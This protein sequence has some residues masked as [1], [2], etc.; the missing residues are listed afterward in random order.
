M[1]SPIRRQRLLTFCAVVIVFMLYRVVQNSWDESATYAGLRTYDKP[2]AA[3]QPPPPT[4]YKAPDVD[5]AAPAVERPPKKPSEDDDEDQRPIGTK[6][7]T[8][9]HD[10][11]YDDAAKA[12]PSS[13][14]SD[15]GQDGTGK[16][17]KVSGEAG[18]D[19]SKSSGKGDLPSYQSSKDGWD[20]QWKKPPSDESNKAL[21]GNEKVHW[22]KTPENFPLPEESIA[23]LPT[24][25][26]KSIPK[27]QYEFGKESESAKQTRQQRLKRVKTEIE[28]SWS[29][30]RKNAWMHDELSPVSG[31]NRDPFCSW[32]ATLV[33]SLDTLWI[34][35]LKDEF[36]EAVQAVRKIDF[37]WTPRNE[38]PVFETTIRYLGGLL[39][40][41][42]VSGG[43]DG[44]YKVLLDKAVE[45][46]EILMGIF[47]TPNRMPLLFYQWQPQ[48]AS[49][50]HRT[51]NVMIAE[52]ATLSMEFTRLSQ[53]TGEDRYYD[54]IDRIT[55]AL[56]DMQKEG[57]HIPGLFPE[58]INASGCN[59]T[60]STLYDDVS[61]EA[62]KQIDSEVPLDEPK[63]YSSSQKSKDP[64]TGGKSA[65]RDVQEGAQGLEKRAVV[66]GEWKTVPDSESGEKSGPLAANGR[67]SDWDC[68]PQ[69]LVPAGHGYQGFH[70]GGAQDS[71]YEYFPKEYLLLG[72]LE[73]KYQ[74]LYEDAVDA[75]NDWLL[76]RPMTDDE[77]D[78]MFTASVSFNDR[79]G[80]DLH[81]QFSITHLT[82]FIGAMYGLG[83]KAFGREADV[84]TA[85]KLTDGCVWA[86]Q[87]MPSGLMPEVSEVIPCPTL[88]KCEFNETL[89]WDK[90]DQARLWRDKETAAWEN[91]ATDRFEAA[92]LRD[93]AELR[94]ASSAEPGSYSAEKA[95]EAKK[96][97]QSAKEYAGST[98]DSP[99]SSIHKRAAVPIISDTKE[100]AESQIPSSLR[101]KL[102]M[103]ED[104]A[105][106]GSA[107]GESAKG[108]SAKQKGE[109]SSGGRSGSSPPGGSVFDHD[110]K[111]DDDT[112][113]SVPSQFGSPG[114]VSSSDR[115]KPTSHEE[116]VKARIKKEGLPPGFTSISQAKYIL[117]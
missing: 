86:Y 28:R 36:D 73:S 94:D 25:K 23:P 101:K 85:K 32:G 41:Y 65:P 31:G 37:T 59:K 56:V 34:V 30:Y 22:K 115:D 2:L 19:A 89:W 26:P 70:M 80:D 69:G 90:L 113:G 117:R 29:G 105:K 96:L 48:F 3:G 88:D 55:D 110:Y 14:K 98:V 39:A 76:F 4:D 58:G 10:A 66:G 84:E 7:G 82:C 1:P 72:G 111:I 17:E 20:V 78:V 5:V 50:P 53:L 38:I 109:S 57:T 60:A 13:G 33:D 83:G 71:A 40:A 81:P 16:S 46:G 79:V 114:R 107:K 100:D 116:F 15:K 24:G 44:K 35:G 42:D 6:P 68:K 18:S 11:D 12:P 62:R 63:G 99:D 102:G 54:A 9:Q 67:T 103:E 95:S 74:K 21:L 8:G 92:R 108:E 52:L 61:A 45:L 91:A 43:P 112:S 47:D 64:A 104:V 75:V 106:G 49:R 51:G 87:L 77:W 27:I 97:K 93:L